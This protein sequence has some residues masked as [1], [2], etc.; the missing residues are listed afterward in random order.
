MAPDLARKEVTH[1]PFI[2]LAIVAIVAIT[3]MTERG[4]KLT[5]APDGLKLDLDGHTPHIESS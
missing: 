1:M 2:A 3:A 5:F 4:G